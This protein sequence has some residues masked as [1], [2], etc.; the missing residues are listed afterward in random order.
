VHCFSILVF[1]GFL[2]FSSQ[3]LPEL[4]RSGPDM[5]EKEDAKVELLDL[6]LLAKKK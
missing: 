2:S 1:E 3:S 6:A 4:M 5:K